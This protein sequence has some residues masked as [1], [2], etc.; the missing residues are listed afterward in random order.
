M[1]ALA[2]FTA[3]VGLTAF[4]LHAEAS[5]SRPHTLLIESPAELDFTLATVDLRG[6]ASRVRLVVHPPTAGRY[7][8][9]AEVLRKPR[10][11]IVLLVNTQ[12]AGTRETGPR[13]VRV[14]IATRLREQAPSLAEHVNILTHGAPGQDCSALTHMGSR[15]VSYAI[16]T[17]F[18]LLTGGVPVMVAGGVGLGSAVEAVARG[19]DQ[20]CGHVLETTFEKWVRQERG[21]AHP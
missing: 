6:P 17:D 16:G 20:A 1:R 18:K 5:P 2:L 7:V 3:I 12:R 9:A 14:E 4:P 13:L 15:P 8:A 11:I 21:P 10:Q 19:L